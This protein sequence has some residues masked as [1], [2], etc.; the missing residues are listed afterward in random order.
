MMKNEGPRSV[1]G[2]GVAQWLNLSAVGVQ[3]IP[4]LGNRQGYPLL[5]EV[6]G[7]TAN[8]L[9]VD[10]PDVEMG[11]VVVTSVRIIGAFPGDEFTLFTTP[12][13]SDGRRQELR[14]DSDG[15]TVTRN[16]PPVTLFN[17]EY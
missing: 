2:D 4:K 5:V 11:G 16:G 10:G 14:T 1:A 7:D 9:V 12:T 6:N 13:L 15:Y 3:F 8:R 17:E